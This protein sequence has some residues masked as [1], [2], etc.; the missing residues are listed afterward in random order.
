MTE[1]HDRQLEKEQERRIIS[2]AEANRRLSGHLGTQVDHY[3]DFGDS[4]SITVPDEL[5]AG[6]LLKITM[7]I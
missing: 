1:E 7:Q 5:A 3:C 6:S 2:S 4:F